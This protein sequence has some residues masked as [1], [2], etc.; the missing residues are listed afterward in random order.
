M[1]IIY[2]DPCSASDLPYQC[3][4]RKE[5][6]ERSD[7]ISLHCP[8]TDETHGLINTTTLELMKPSALLINASRGPVVDTTALTTA[9]IDKRIAGAALDVTDPEPLPPEH[10]LFRLPNC[11]V[12]PHIGSA[13]TGTR[14]KMAE[15]ACENLLAGLKGLRLPYCVNPK[16]YE[17]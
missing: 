7:I 12:V 9:L 5:L 16:V 8:L 11:L 13:T 10:P 15:M 6:F 17:K 14:Q 2:S 4:S 3:V 1:E